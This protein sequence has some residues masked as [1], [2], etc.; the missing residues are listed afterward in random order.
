[1]KTT[2]DDQNTEMGNY[3]QGANRNFQEEYD[4]LRKELEEKTRKLKEKEIEVEKS[5]QL[6]SVFDQKMKDI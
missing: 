2:G 5:N 1:M 4:R 6:F 3:E